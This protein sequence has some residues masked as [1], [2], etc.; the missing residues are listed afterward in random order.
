MNMFP[1]NAALPWVAVA[2]FARLQPEQIPAGWLG[3][4]IA[5]AVVSGMAYW[6]AARLRRKRRQYSHDYLFA[7]LCALHRLNR[8]SRNLLKQLAR[9]HNLGHP[10][11]M[12]LEPVWLDPQRLPQAL[13][14]RA[15]EIV[16]LRA[17]L[18]GIGQTPAEALDA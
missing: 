13:H 18:F 14:A 15:E 11:R 16:K 17:E 12:F 8:P 5:V 9:Y 6:H 1:I 4:I 2:V 10:A 3:A 7:D